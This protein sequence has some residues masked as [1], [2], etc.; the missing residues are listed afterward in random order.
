MN[1]VLEHVTVPLSLGAL[2][3]VIFV[4]TFILVGQANRHQLELIDRGAAEVRVI[5]LGEKP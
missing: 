4:G 3:I 5:P 2:A 1:D